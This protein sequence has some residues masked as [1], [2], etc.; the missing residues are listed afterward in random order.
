MTLVPSSLK[1]IYWHCRK[2]RLTRCLTSIGTYTEDSFHKHEVHGEFE[3]LLEETRRERIQEAI[4]KIGLESAGCR[5]EEKRREE[6]RREEKRREDILFGGG[7]SY[8]GG[9]IHEGSV[10]DVPLMVVVIVIV[11]HA[12]NTT[13]AGCTLHNEYKP[14]LKKIYLVFYRSFEIRSF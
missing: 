2:I 4:L 12:C 7:D 10:S 6:K 14:T 1:R 3:V 11:F 5:S 13:D 8:F 9:G